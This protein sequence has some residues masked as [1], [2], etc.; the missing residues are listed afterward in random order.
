MSFI[1]TVYRVRVRML[2]L[3]GLLAVLRAVVRSR[4][5]PVYFCASQSTVSH[6]EWWRRAMPPDTPAKVD[7]LGFILHWVF[8][9]PRGAPEDGQPKP[10]LET[11]LALPVSPKSSPRAH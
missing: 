1:H 2:V 6:E 10:Q 4:G 8:I 3:R 5:T 9:R 11:G 7:R